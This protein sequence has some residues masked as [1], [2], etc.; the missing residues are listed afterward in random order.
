[1]PQS[2]RGPL[3]GVLYTQILPPKC[4]LRGMSHRPCLPRSRRFLPVAPASEPFSVALEIM[5]PGVGPRSTESGFWEK[6]HLDAG[7]M[8]V[9]LSDWQVDSS[10]GMVRSLNFLRKLGKVPM[11]PDQTRC[12]QTQRCRQFLTGSGSVVGMLETEQEMLDIPFG[13]TFKVVLRW[14][15]VQQDEGR[16]EVRKCALAFHEAPISHPCSAG[17][18]RCRVPA[19]TV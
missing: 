7:D 8:D 6:I 14:T 3:R 13:D 1:M 9:T 17:R 5:T 10:L 2:R 11:G 4:V 15:F 16:S 12:V 19:S 18:L